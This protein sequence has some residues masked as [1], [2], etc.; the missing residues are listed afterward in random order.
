LFSS[1]C[2]STSS[3][4]QSLENFLPFAWTSFILALHT[5]ER[6]ILQTEF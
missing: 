6:E 5:H 1:T 3:W 4:S 2:K